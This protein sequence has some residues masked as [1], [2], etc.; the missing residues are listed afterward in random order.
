MRHV[1][2]HLVFCFLC[3]SIS[4]SQIS[5]TAKHVILISIDGFR[6]N[7]YLEEQWATP[8]LKAL[9]KSGVHAEGLRPVVPSTTVPNH[10]TMITGALPAR[11]GIYFNQQFDP[12]SWEAEGY[13]YAAQIKVP[14]LWDA[15]KKAGGTSAAIRWVVAADNPSIDWHIW[16]D[17]RPE[18]VSPKGFLEELEQHVIGKRRETT[19]NNDFDYYRTDLQSANIAAYIIKTYKP[20]LLTARV[21]CTDYFQHEQGREGYKVEKAIQVADLYVSQVIEATKA[22]GIYDETTFIIVGDHGFENY[23]TQLAWNSLLIKE[24]L[25]SD[26]PDRGNWKACF[27]YQFLMLRDKNDTITRKKVRSLL[28]NQP[29][30]I[31][32]LYRVVERTELDQYGAIPDAALAIQPVEGVYCNS[33]SD[34]TELL[35]AGIGGAHGNIP[36]RPNLFSGFI[37]HGKGIRSGVQMPTLNMED[38]APLIAHLLGLDFQAPDGVLYPGIL[39]R[40]LFR[41]GDVRD[42]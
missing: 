5:G 8:T 3:S 32:K 23:H 1:I 21:R 14:T 40:N 11:H 28:E 27:H 33:R 9:A 16:A 18:T 12:D 13:Q 35:I 7:F 34:A 15:V 42:R 36:D 20:T 24:G 37:A 2:F 29:P 19:E 41:F 25:L 30:N 6:P 22:A 4:F 39:E 10:T 26:A 17:Y 31:R 38:I